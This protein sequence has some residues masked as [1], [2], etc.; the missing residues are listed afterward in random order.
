MFTYLIIKSYFSIFRWISF[1][2]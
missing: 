2:S 1:R